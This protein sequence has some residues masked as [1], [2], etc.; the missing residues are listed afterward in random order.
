MY[1]LVFGMNANLTIDSADDPGVNPEVV[2]GDEQHAQRQ[3]KA[4]KRVLTQ[5]RREKSDLQDANTRLGVELKDVRAQLADCVKENKRLRC[6]V[7]S[8]CLNELL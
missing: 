3:L 7:F 8:K 1:Q 2:R 5:V 6:G 4:G